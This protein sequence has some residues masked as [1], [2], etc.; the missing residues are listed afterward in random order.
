MYFHIM[1]GSGSVSPGDAA[2]VAPTAAAPGKAPIQTD[3]V[4]PFLLKMADTFS[5]KRELLNLFLE[6]LGADQD[7]DVEDLLSIPS[8][9][10]ESTVK[11]LK[12]TIDGEQKALSPLETGNLLKYMSKLRAHVAPPEKAAPSGQTP[13][14]DTTAPHEQ[15]VKRKV[16]EVLDQLDDHAFA[17]PDADECRTL[18]GN[19][20]QVCG[21]K[22]PE[23]EAPTA[24]QLGALKSKMDRRLAPYCDFAVFGPNG[25]RMAKI[26]RFEAQVFINNELKQKVLRGPSDFKAWT[27]S[28]RVFRTAMISL[29]AAAPQTL[30]NYFRGIEQLIILYPHAWGLVFCADELM[31]SEVW[32]RIREEL[33]DDK[34]WPENLPWDLVI[35]MSAYGKGDAD[36]QHWWFTHVVAPATQGGGGRTTVAHLDG[37]SNLP[38]TDGLYTDAAKRLNNRHQKRG[39]RAG[40]HSSTP[41]FASGKGAWTDYSKGKG[42]DHWTSGKGK[43]KNSKGKNKGHGKNE[44]GKHGKGKMSEPTK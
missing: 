43:S 25:R 20:K 23:Q 30:D 27:E 41:A 38:S 2:A 5:V 34:E 35:R 17:I 36:R 19:Y 28:W 6:A 42:A 16:A 33:E 44:N 21:G 3:S 18:R 37:S 31:R 8:D 7:S 4:T 24:D 13:V 29:K 26:M 1:S 39:G 40:T 22:A 15:G 32:D 11:D 9:M 12:K 14:V 10:I